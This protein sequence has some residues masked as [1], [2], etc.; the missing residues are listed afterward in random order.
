M[1]GSRLGVSVVVLAL[2]AGGLW[3]GLAGRRGVSVQLTPTAVPVA[4]S[5]APGRSIDLTGWKLVLPEAGPN[6]D[7]ASITPASVF[8]PWLVRQ[9]DGTLRFWA[10]VCGASTP[11]SEHPRTE[12]N[13]LTNFTAGTSGRRTLAASLAVSQVPAAGGEVII[14]QIHGAENI[15]SVPFVM[16]RYGSGQL[17]VVVKKRQSGSDSDKFPLLGGIPLGG[18]FNYL[19]SDNGDGTLTVAASHG[20]DSP[21]VTIPI[22]VPFLGSTVR[23]QAGAYQQGDAY[24]GGCGASDGALVTFAALQQTPDAR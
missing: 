15:S 1:R 12:L 4:P 23:F 20:V 17:S 24:V 10:P 19:I 8:P 13:S 9:P 21:N 3:F 18:W 5:P 11:N 22:P 6:G 16:L 2:L 7:V 14:G